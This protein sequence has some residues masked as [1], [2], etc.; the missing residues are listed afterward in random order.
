MVGIIGSF[1]PGLGTAAG[2]TLGAYWGFGV[3]LVYAGVTEVIGNL[4]DLIF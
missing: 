1:V 4:W 2:A 3:G